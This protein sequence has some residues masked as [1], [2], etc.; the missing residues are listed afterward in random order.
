MLPHFCT[1]GL[2][3][4]ECLSVINELPIKILVRT[5]LLDRY[6]QGTHFLRKITLPN[7]GSVY[8]FVIERGRVEATSKVVSNDKSAVPESPNQKYVRVA[9]TDGD[10]TEIRVIRTCRVEG[11][12]FANY[13]IKD[14]KSE[15]RRN[16]CRQ[17]HQ[18]PFSVSKIFCFCVRLLSRAGSSTEEMVISRGPEFLSAR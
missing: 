6:V 16:H 13:R 4:P 1:G 17:R 11:G 5:S 2:E 12:L 9:R 7:L 8:I 18:K 3:V 10:P 15:S 14:Q